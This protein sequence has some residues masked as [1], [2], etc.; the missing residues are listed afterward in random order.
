MRA[1]FFLVAQF[2]HQPL[3][4]IQRFLRVRSACLEGKYRSLIEIR[5]EHVHE[6]VRVK[7]RSFADEKDLAP[8]PLN[9]ADELRRRPRVQSQFIQYRQLLG[10]LLG[11]PLLSK[12]HVLENGFKFSWLPSARAESRASLGQQSS[13]TIAPDG[14]GLKGRFFVSSCQSNWL[15]H[16][17]IQPF[18]SGLPIGTL[19]CAH[20]IR[21]TGDFIGGGGD[22]GEAGVFAH[23]EDFAG[24]VEGD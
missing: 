12:C 2:D 6:P 18:R 14:C 1:F 7:T 16:C 19:R 21:H 17:F 15:T 4:M 20:R 24:G 8:V 13:I 22:A 5:Q 23:R 11:L 9:T 3:E 10:R